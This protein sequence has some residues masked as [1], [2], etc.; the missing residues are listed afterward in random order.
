LVQ[1]PGCAPSDFWHY[2][3]TAIPRPLWPWDEVASWTAQ[4]ILLG[5]DAD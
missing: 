1:A 4:P 5:V 3:Y 2:P